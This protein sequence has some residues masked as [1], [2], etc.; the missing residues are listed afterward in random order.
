MIALLLT[1]ALHLAA[2]GHGHGFWPHGVSYGP[3][4][5]YPGVVSTEIVNGV[6]YEVLPGGQLVAVASPSVVAGVL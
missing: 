6:T 1:A 5:G 4:F 2:G 3:G